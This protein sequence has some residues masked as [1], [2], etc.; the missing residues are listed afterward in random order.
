MHRF[1]KQIEL[2]VSA[3]EA[4]AWHE[5]PGAFA[6]LNPPWDPVEVM[7][8]TGGVKTGARV[9]LRARAGPFRQVMEFRHEAYQAGVQFCDRQV[10]GP[11]RSWF[12]EHKF[13]PVAEG[14]CR[15]VDRITYTLPLGRIG[16]MLGQSFVARKLERLFYYRH[17]T[18][19]MDTSLPKIQPMNILVSGGTGLLGRALIPLLTTQGHRVRLLTRNPRGDDMIGWNPD[20]AELKEEELEGVD[21]VIHLA[22]ETVAQKWTPEAK[23]RIRKSRVVGTR[24]LA[25]RLAGLSKPPA[26]LISA[27]GINVYGDDRDELLD[28]DSSTGDSFLAEVCKAWEAATAPAEA[29]GIR[30]VHLRLGAVLSPEGGAL[31]KLLPVFQKGIGGRVGKGDQRFSW[32]SIE[33]AIGVLEFLLRRDDISG[34][35]N[36]VSPKVVDNAEL[37]RTLGKVLGKP[38]FLPVPALAIKMMFGEMGKATV[39]GNLHVVPKRL[40]AANYDFRFESLE[41]ALSHLLGK[42]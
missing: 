24:L 22:G 21:A 9:R 11:F 42:A 29:A 6:R 31:A 16:A 4:F 27:S 10:R 20:A 3:R 26:V 7:E 25:E 37:T 17:T 19:Y 30:V 28:E 5:R 1:E 34:P 40:E 18:T 33:D 41:S 39:L 35:V 38:T 32:I 23:R 14:R 2:P 8:Q 15:L 13:E 12:H 36:G